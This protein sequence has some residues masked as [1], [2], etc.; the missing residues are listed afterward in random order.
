MLDA[1]PL[2]LAHCPANVTE[3]LL[4]KYTAET[5]RRMLRHVVN[6]TSTVDMNSELQLTATK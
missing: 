5:I 4:P 2:Q 6:N 3:R 1:L